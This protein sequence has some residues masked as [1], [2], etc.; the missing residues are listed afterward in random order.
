MIIEVAMF[1]GGAI[2]ALSTKE[3]FEMNRTN[4]I[5]EHIELEDRILSKM[6]FEP[7]VDKSLYKDLSEHPF[8]VL[9]NVVS[10]EQ[11]NKVVPVIK[12]IHCEYNGKKYVFTISE[13]DVRNDGGVLK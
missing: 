12:E 9:K 3:L 6:V 10:I 1:V 13:I 11:D 7:T 5:R 8:E 4:H 2:V